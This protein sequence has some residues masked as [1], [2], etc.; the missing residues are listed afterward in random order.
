M[1]VPKSGVPVA[2]DAVPTVTGDVA[3]SGAPRAVPRRRRRCEHHTGSYGC[4]GCEIAVG[5]RA[6]SGR[7]VHHTSRWIVKHAVGRLDRGTLVVALRDPRRRVGIHHR[8]APLTGGR[9]FAARLA[10]M[11]PMAMLILILVAR[12]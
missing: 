12:V 7:I 3:A 10:T 1:E 4:L 9:A 6:V 2:A 8:P 5:Q 11:Q